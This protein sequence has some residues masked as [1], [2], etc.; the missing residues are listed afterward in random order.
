MFSHKWDIDITSPVPEAQGSWLKK[1]N[2]ESQVVDEDYDTLFSRRSRAVAH[3]NSCDGMHKTST[4][5]GQTKLQHGEG[6]LSVKP[7]L[8]NCWK[9]TA[10]RR[11]G[12]R[13]L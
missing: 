5:S 11:R 12:I 2:L 10:A 9:L 8:K 6:R 1:G 13:F 7:S 3:V 4:G